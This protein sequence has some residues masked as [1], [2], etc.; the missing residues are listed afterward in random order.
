MGDF[1]ARSGETLEIYIGMKK[2]VKPVK[3]WLFQQRYNIAFLDN[4]L[5]EIMDGASLNI[6]PMKHQYRDRWFADPFIISADDREI[7]L[8]V[9]EKY[10][11]IQRGRIARLT[12]DRRSYEL[13]RNE[14]ILQLDTHLSFPAIMREGKYLWIYPESIESGHL[15]AYKLDVR[16]NQIEE[17]KTFAEHSLADAV[18][19]KKDGVS[20]LFATTPPDV[21]GKELKIYKIDSDGVYCHHQTIFFNENTARSAGDFFEYGGGIFRV[22]Q[23][24]NKRYGEAVIIQKVTY[25]GYWKFEEVRRLYSDVKYWNLGLHTF[26]VK[27]GCIVCDLKG[28]RHSRIACVLIKIISVIRMLKY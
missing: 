25:D 26:N 15:M 10:Y 12:V 3:Q 20:Y 6:K 13:I 14:T 7:D 28:Y 8:L 11:P 18:I 17:K 9:E 23:I 16:T 1:V 22:A 24:C 27:D 2:I 4:S 21:N 19:F 5:D